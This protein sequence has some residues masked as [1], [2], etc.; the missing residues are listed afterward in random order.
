MSGNKRRV[1]YLNIILEEFAT[2]E[3][4]KIETKT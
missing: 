2:E 3:E 4:E 1:L